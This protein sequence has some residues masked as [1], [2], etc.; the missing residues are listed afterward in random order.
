MCVCVWGV[1]SI[2][3]TLAGNERKRCA[4]MFRTKSPTESTKSVRVRMDVGD[5]LYFEKTNS[6]EQKY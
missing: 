5:S 1:L 6:N 2:L 3:T 4:W